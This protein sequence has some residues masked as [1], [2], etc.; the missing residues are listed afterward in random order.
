MT[1]RD[2][3]ET[4]QA[5]LTP[6]E[7]ESAPEAAEDLGFGSVIGG[8]HEHRLLGRDGSFTSRRLGFSPLSYLNGYHALLTITWP[9]FLGIV[10]AAYLALN[11]LFAWAFVLCGAVGLGGAD[12]GS[13]GGRWLR[14]FFFSVQT[15]A[16]IGYGHVFPVGGAAN[17]VVTIES[18]VSL[19]AV[20]L[21]TGI[22]FA[23]FSRPTAAVLFSNVAVIG[24]YQGT[25]GFMFRITNAR[26]NQ[27]ME[28]EAKVLFSRLDGRGRRYDQLKL[29]RTK[30]VFFPLSW[31]IVHP[32]VESSPLWGCSHQDLVDQDAEFLILLSGIDETFAQMVHARSSYKPPEIVYGMKFSNIYNPV[33]ADG[34]ISID[35]SRLSEIEGTPMEDDVST[36][37]QT[38]RHTGHFTGFAPPRPNRPGKDSTP[39]KPDSR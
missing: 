5:S 6:A 24:P 15:F 13:T 7:R 38:F 4:V 20:A 19:L 35:V 22:V 9:R 29:E 2:V 10:A 16:T 30:V 28:L 11:A 17:W 25:T 3:R 34:T 27:L 31:T 33:S 1:D 36:H 23:R 8:A 32:I 12:D 14:A 18:L 26:S 37:T 21:M 39:R